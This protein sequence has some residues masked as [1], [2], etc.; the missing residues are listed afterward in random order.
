MLLDN[1]RSVIELS[2]Q[3]KKVDQVLENCFF[4]LFSF[5]FFD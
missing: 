4:I 3:G 2:S 5:R 1:E